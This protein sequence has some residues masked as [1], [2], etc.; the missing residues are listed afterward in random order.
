[1]VVPAADLL[2]IGLDYTGYKGKRQGSHSVNTRRFRAAYCVAPETVES[3]IA[4]LETTNVPAARIDRPDI[5][6]LLLTLDFAKTY[7]TGDNLG[8]H[9]NLDPKTIRAAVWGKYL[10]AIQALKEEKVSRNFCR[11]RSS[12][13]L[14]RMPLTLSSPS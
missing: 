3:V 4:D 8:G 10:P 6:R 12:P 1:M 9:W 14:D 2:R 13:P 7:Q 11:P 5:K